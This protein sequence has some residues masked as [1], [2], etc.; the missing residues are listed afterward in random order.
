MKHR[1]ASA[2]LALALAALAPEAQAQQFAYT[3]KPVNLRAGP[4]RAYPVV[5][6][7]P[8]AAQVVVQGCIP[9]YRWCDV[10][11]GLERGWVYA[12]NLRYAS[13]TGPVPL[14]GIAPQVGI[15]VFPFVLYDYWGIH[16]RDRPWYPDRE[17]WLRPRP[18][19]LPPPPPRYQPPPVVHPRPPGVRPQDGRNHAPPR[20]GVHPGPGVH[21]PPGGNP[22]PGVHPPPRTQ[23]PPGVRPPPRTQPPPGVRPPPRTQPSDGRVRPVPPRPELPPAR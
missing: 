17:R 13:V 11:F 4:D 18:R 15:A 23:P 21:P 2:L 7:L 16:Y 6:V 12:G 10:S 19:A 1:V 20:P 3:A 8:A 9:D 22:Q 5:V 14:I